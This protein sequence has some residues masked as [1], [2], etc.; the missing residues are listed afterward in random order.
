MDKEFLKLAAAQLL[1]RGHHRM[2][3]V[4]PGNPSLLVKVPKAGRDNMQGRIE[5]KYYKHLEARAVPLDHIAACHGEVQT[6]L[7]PG[8]VL[9]RVWLDPAA[10]TGSATLAETIT[11]GLTDPSSIQQAMD[12][13]ADYLFRHNILWSDEN[14]A[15]LAVVLGPGIRLVIIDG[16]G[17][18]NERVLKQMLLQRVPW[19][20]RYY[21]MP[22]MRRL[23]ERVAALE[24]ED[25]GRDVA[26]FSSSC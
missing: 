4:H 3:Y 13:L 18:R 19:L 11:R 6:D 14:P 7:G 17:G 21:T 23:R 12:R 20:A 2:V 9:E 16:L 1:A 15:N 26:A 8:L 10:R 24:R 5:W 22:K 25:G